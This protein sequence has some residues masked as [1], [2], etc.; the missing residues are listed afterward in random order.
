MKTVFIVLASFIAGM[1]FASR[2]T[3][4]ASPCTVATDTISNYSDTTYGQDTSS[5]PEYTPDIDFL[6]GGHIPERVD[7]PKVIKE[8]FEK[9][10]YRDTVNT[11]YGLVF[12]YDTVHQNRLGPRQV[13]FSLDSIPII[14]NTITLKEKPRNQVFFGL[15][16]QWNTGAR[17]MGVGPSLMFKTKR[18]QVF[19]IG[20][21]IDTKSQW[22]YQGSIKIPI[23]LHH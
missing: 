11:K 19:E 4:G 5:I 15:N 17:T 13:L 10:V 23:S 2:C 22:I 7:T 1:F 8:Y 16:G 21:L 18:N 12:I 6:E 20:A 9:V 14:T 3:P